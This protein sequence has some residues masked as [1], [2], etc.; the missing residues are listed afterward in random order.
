MTSWSMFELDAAGLRGIENPRLGREPLRLK[1]PGGGQD[2]G[3]VV[4]LV[5][6]RCGAW[7]ATST[8]IP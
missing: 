5:A 4:A 2:V 3:K 1:L 7:I 8:A 6:S